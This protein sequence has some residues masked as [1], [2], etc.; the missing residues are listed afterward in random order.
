MAKVSEDYIC[1]GP[2][3]EGLDWHR[4]EDGSL[5]LRPAP[6][7][8][9]TEQKRVRAKQLTTYILAVQRLSKEPGATV[10]PTKVP[11]QGN[12]G[13]LVLYIGTLPEWFRE[14]MQAV[15]MTVQTKTPDLAN[16]VYGVPFTMPGCVRLTYV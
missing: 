6:G 2:T 14:A 10:K 16:A 5:E 15:P 8:R 12:T 4:A 7:T 1:G 3:G 13:P 11:Y 9:D